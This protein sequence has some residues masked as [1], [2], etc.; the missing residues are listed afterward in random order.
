MRECEKKIKSFLDDTCKLLKDT[1][2][3]PL[4]SMQAGCSHHLIKVGPI[5]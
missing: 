4:A 3:L 2:F 1:D 5:E